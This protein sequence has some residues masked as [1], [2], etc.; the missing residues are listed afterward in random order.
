G[1]RPDI[2]PSTAH[3]K[4]IRKSLACALSGITPQ[5]SRRMMHLPF[6]GEPAAGWPLRALRALRS[7]NVPAFT[8]FGVPVGR[9]DRRKWSRSPSLANVQW[10]DSDSAT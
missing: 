2:D 1:L 10:H 9:R 6:A 3:Q 7:L 4:I 5:N 8:S